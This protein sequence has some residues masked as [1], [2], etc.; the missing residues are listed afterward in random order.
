MSNS[1]LRALPRH[2]L[3]FVALLAAFAA[4]WFVADWSATHNAGPANAASAAQLNR[5]NRPQIPE[6][7]VEGQQPDTPRPELPQVPEIADEPKTIDPATLVPEALAKPV[8]VDFSDSSLRE[9]A[10]WLQS[11]QGVTTLFDN[12]AL[13][14]EG[15]PL[16]EPVS[17]HL[18]NEPLYL[19]LN[20]L[21]SKGLAWYMNDDILTIT[22]TDVM[23]D[24][25]STQSYSIGDLFEA[26]YEMDELD[27]AIR[28]MTSDGWLESGT[29]IGTMEWL[30]DIVFVR[31][32][33]QQ[34]REVAGFLRALRGH[35]RRTFTFDPPQHTEIRALLEENV[36]VDFD[37]TPL[38]AAVEELSS[39]SGVDIRL[40]TAGLRLEGIRDR[41][42]VS[43]VL[44]DRKLST[45]LQVLVSNLNLD[46]V[47]MDGVL[48]ITTKDTAE[49][50]V[51]MAL[52]DVRDLCQSPSECDALQE[53]ILS[54]T[55]GSWLDDGTGS[56]AIE[57]PKTGVM[58][59]RNTERLHDQILRLLTMYREALSNSVP[60]DHGP[61]PEEEIVTYYY[62][63]PANV[64]AEM[65]GKLPQLVAAGSW[66]RNN[67]AN[68]E[69]PGKIVS[70]ESSPAL[71]DAKGKSVISS[72]EPGS[73]AM[74]VPQRV[75]MITQTR[76]NHGE[77]VTFLDRVRQGQEPSLNAGGFGGI[78]GGGGGFGGGLYQ[79]RPKP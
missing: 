5:A 6:P 53:A 2:G 72:G 13:A 32:G 44:T 69:L 76:K 50:T 11:E 61:T 20:R 67:D 27:N 40:D 52:Y 74:V 75:L 34:Q 16:G 1:Q 14:E 17:D 73:S 18:N 78:G 12:N 25:A 65:Y 10:D 4:V 42:P 30:G 21:R 33:D 36:S 26:G 64:A 8:T 41:E 7:T 15:I 38:V 24:Q 59:V 22:T 62:R 68:S 66:N 28:D 51:K 60:R 37:L 57:F 56:G 48:W 70:L 54:Q 47:L 49:Q 58:A 46:W 55:E 3:K 79:P 35:A 29:G 31:Q 77:I 71:L 9:V 63:L 39:S 43:L 19:L 45:V 23:A